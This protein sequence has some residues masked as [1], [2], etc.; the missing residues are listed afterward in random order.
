MCWRGA[1]KGGDKHF[2]LVD[3]ENLGGGDNRETIIK[4]VALPDC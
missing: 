3:E 1:G 2:K 4:Y